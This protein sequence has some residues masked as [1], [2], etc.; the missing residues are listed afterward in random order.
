M[1]THIPTSG[2]VSGVRVAAT[3]MLLFGGAL[4]ASPAHAV[5]V[6]I[7]ARAGIS[8]PTSLRLPAGPSA[9]VDLTWSPFRLVGFEAVVDQSLHWVDQ[10]T[11][12][13]RVGSTSASLG[14]QYRVDVTSVLPYVALALTARRLQAQGGAPVLLFGGAVGLGVLVPLGSN[15]FVGGEARY[16]VQSDGAFPVAQQY[17]LRF[18]WRFGAFG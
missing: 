1:S 3:W 11:H 2:T 7:G 13:T 12:V 14:V 18:G 5:P 15:L 10:E 6:W 4:S 17:V 8:A 16:G 9:G